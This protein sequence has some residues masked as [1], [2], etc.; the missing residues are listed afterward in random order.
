M[1]HLATKEVG[2]MNFCDQQIRD[3][4]LVMETGPA[5]CVSHTAGKSLFLVWTIASDVWLLW[6]IQE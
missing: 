4:E 6:R 2:K 3:R 5:S 1:C